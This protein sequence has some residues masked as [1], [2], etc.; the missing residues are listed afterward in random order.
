MPDDNV[1]VICVK[2]SHGFK[3]NVR[4]CNQIG[5]VD[6]DYYDN[7]K[8]EG[9]IWVSLQNEGDKDFV[10][11]R[12]DGFAQGIFLPYFLTDDDE[13]DSKNIRQLLDDRYLK[14]DE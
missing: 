6:K 10:I 2:G 5:V 3:Y 12:G 1:L 8:N 13:L 9:H 4:L 7:S 11:N 14:G